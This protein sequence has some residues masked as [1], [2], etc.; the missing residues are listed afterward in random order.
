MTIRFGNPSLVDISVTVENIALDTG[1]SFIMPAD[2]G[3]GTVQLP[4]DPRH[5]FNQNVN[6]V[7][8]YVPE[9]RGPPGKRE[10]KQPQRQNRK[11]GNPEAGSRKWHK[12]STVQ[13]LITIRQGERFRV[14]LSTM[15]NVQA[16]PATSKNIEKVPLSED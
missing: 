8:V 5:Y 7:L 3:F 6:I 14:A 2:M 15:S 4:V 13:R 9:T 16:A 1:T 12:I 11:G 10:D